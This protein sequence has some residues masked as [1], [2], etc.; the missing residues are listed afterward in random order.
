MGVFPVVPDFATRCRVQRGKGGLT[1][2][3]GGYPPPP[4]NVLDLALDKRFEQTFWTK[5]NQA[6]HVR[7]ASCGHTGGLSCL[8]MVLFRSSLGTYRVR[9][10]FELKYKLY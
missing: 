3:Y 9:Y 1:L 10:H 7:Y 2:T 5:K 4:K 8:L 6:G